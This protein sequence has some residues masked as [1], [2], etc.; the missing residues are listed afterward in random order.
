MF[1]LIFFSFITSLYRYK[2]SVLSLT[3]VAYVCYHMTRKPIAVVKSVL[4]QNCSDV[5]PRPDNIAPGNQTWCDYPPFGNELS[6]LNLKRFVLTVVSHYRW[7]RCKCTSRDLRFQLPLF[8][9]N[10]NVPFW[11]YC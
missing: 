8:L 10:C 6:V 1:I 4:H 5:L 3:Y 7:T 2:V 9:C 11:I